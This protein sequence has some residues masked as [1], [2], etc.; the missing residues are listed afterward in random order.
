MLA[1]YKLPRLLIK[2]GIKKDTVTITVSKVLVLTEL[3]DKTLT[4]PF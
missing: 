1:G 2:L 3:P 4:S